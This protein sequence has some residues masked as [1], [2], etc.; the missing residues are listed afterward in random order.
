MALLKEASLDWCSIIQLVHGLGRGVLEEGQRPARARARVRDESASWACILALVQIERE[1][2]GRGCI[3]SQNLAW[4]DLLESV[5]EGNKRLSA[6]MLASAWILQILFY[7]K[8]NWYLLWRW[9]RARGEVE[10]ERERKQR[11]R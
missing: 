2:F 8:R 7:V 11:G 5:V 10:S 4:V 3:V 6:D 1:D 9:K